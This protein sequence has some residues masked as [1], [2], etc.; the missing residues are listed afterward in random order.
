MIK[1]ILSKNLI[2]QGLL[3]GFIIFTGMIKI[4]GDTFFFLVFNTSDF[5]FFLWNTVISL[6]LILM[7]SVF[8]FYKFTKSE[9]NERENTFESYFNDLKIIIILVL[10]L[11]IATILL[12]DSLNQRLEISGVIAFVYVELL[13]LFGIAIGFYTLNFLFRW[14]WFRRHRKTKTYLRTLVF[15]L[16]F[17]LFFEIINQMTIRNNDS[18]VNLNFILPIVDSLGLIIAFM[19]ARKNTWIAYLPKK[20]KWKLILISSFIN[21]IALI[22]VIQTFNSNESGK[23]YHALNLFFG[24]APILNFAFMIS[25]AY[26]TRIFFAAI[27]ALPTTRIVEQRTYEIS[28]LTFLNRMVAQTTDTENLLKTVTKLALNSSGASS[29]WTEIYT[30]DGKVNVVSAENMDAQVVEQFHSENEIKN[31]FITLTE[32]L[33]IET[34]K[35]CKDKLLGDICCILKSKSLIA[36]PLFAGEERIGTLVV[37][38]PEE[39]S[40]E[41]DYINVLTAF[42]DNVNVALENTR[43]WE[44][45]LTKERYK[46]EMM[47]A[48]EIEEKLLPQHLPLLKNYSLAAFALPAQE[49]GGDYYDI[50]TLKNGKPC[51]LIGDVSGKGMS[52]AFYMA[53]LKGVVLGVAKES[54]S[55]IEL[56]KKINST[57]FH[58]MEKQMFITLSALMPEN[59]FGTFKFARAGHTYAFVKQNDEV[60]SFLPKGIGIGLANSAKFNSIAEETEIRLNHNDSILLYTDGITE[61]KKSSGEEFDENS[62]KQILNFSVYNNAGMLVDN[63]KS[64]I[65]GFIDNNEQKDDMTVFAIHYTN[66]DETQ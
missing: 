10:I 12:P 20:K 54:D 22:I 50:V 3:I 9:E 57:L 2:S 1:K 49:V 58:V 31:Y 38:H 53:L 59:E 29:A 24:A 32:P 28:S 8:A 36:I 6:T 27:F 45:S 42:S 51:I 61:L 7:G 26:F 16:G 60:V 56:I 41:R 18:D 47:L 52:A 65:N 15:L 48:K 39:F 66:N 46:K 37:L 25:I 23:L 34:V 17:S 33:F 4:I 44:E 5:P 30:K 43:L 11:L 62:L 63:I 64:G 35:D 40:F 19:T 55:P 14:L 21:I 13:S